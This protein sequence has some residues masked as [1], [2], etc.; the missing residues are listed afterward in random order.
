MKKKYEELFLK[1]DLKEAARRTRNV[2]PII[3]AELVID[4]ELKEIVKDKKYL[5]RTFGCQ[6]NERDEENIAGILEECGYTKATCLEDADLII[7]NTCAVRENAEERVFGEIGNLKRLKA[8]NPELL[9]AICGCMV[10]EETMV[11]QILAKH[12]QVDII[13]GTH[14]IINLPSILLKAYANKARVVEV[15][16]K[17]GEVYE[18]LPSVRNGKL[19][20]W[21]NIMYGCDKFCTY[22]IVP[23]TRGKERSRLMEDI[24]DEVKSLKEDGYQEITLLGQN[25]NAYGKDLQAEYDFA[26]LL[27]EVA[28]TGIPRIRFT[29]SH[30]WDFNSRMIEAI[31]DYDNIMPFVHLPLQSGDSDVLRRMGRRYT[32]EEYKRLYNEIREKVPGVSITTDII[33]GFPNETEEQFNNTLKA[34]DELAYDGAFTFIYSPRTGTP[35]ARMVDEVSMEDKHIRFNKLVDIINKRGLERNLAYEGKVLKVLVEGTSKR[36]KEILSGYSEENK[37]VNFKGSEENIGK[38][39]KVKITKAKTYTLEGEEVHE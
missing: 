27:V 3:R 14:N 30:P 21:V 18:N 32:Y 1:P 36:N 35:A 4:N 33:V 2:T 25:V 7:L 5:V 12:R 31:R 24:L 23:Y 37:L 39:V 22:C 11:E 10:Q 19:K 34:A 8:N 28:K 38:I 17:E 15:Y 26:T 6:A 20:A 29:T 16:S 9:F 13:F